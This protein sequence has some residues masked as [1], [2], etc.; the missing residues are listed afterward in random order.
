MRIYFQ[1]WHNN[2][3]SATE[4]PSVWTGGWWWLSFF[5]S[6]DSLMAKS[7]FI[8]THSHLDW[9]LHYQVGTSWLS[10]HAC[11][12]Q[13]QFSRMSHYQTTSST[14]WSQHLSLQQT[15]GTQIPKFYDIAKHTTAATK[16]M[17]CTCLGSSPLQSRN[18]LHP[19]FCLHLWCACPE[20]QSKP[21]LCIEASPQWDLGA[22]LWTI[23]FISQ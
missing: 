6:S 19:L 5:R 7:F 9:N 12:T 1:G 15:P 22:K 20:P 3:R 4:R 10:V 17:T 8:S 2:W 18:M 16:G 21:T 14:S 13:H 11:G 23:L